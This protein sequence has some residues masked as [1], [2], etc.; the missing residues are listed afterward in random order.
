MRVGVAG[1]AAWA[2]GLETRAS[3]RD[4]ARTP[5]PLAWEGQPD[6]RFL[7]AMLRRRCTPL[8]RILLWVAMEACPK[9]QR[10]QVRTVFASRHGSIN[11]SVALLEN[12][13]RGEKLSPGRFSHTVH[14][15]QAGLF[16]IA[17]GNRCASSSLAAREDSFGCGLLESL[18][19]LEREPERPVLFVTGDVPLDPVFASL[20]DEPACAYG[21]GLLLSRDAGQPGFRV[22]I[23]PGQRTE[24]SPWPPAAAFLGGWLREEPRFR[25][26]TARHTWSFLRSESGEETEVSSSRDGAAHDA[27]GSAR[28]ASEHQ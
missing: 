6:P 14:N 27:R 7:P 12:V 26:E 16:S 25:L 28:D 11:E 23:T 2:P 1:W 24:R 9:E 15:A 8:S 3:W 5:Q 10:A 4:W 13:A 17:T 21:V 19:H 18:G 20:V 22:A